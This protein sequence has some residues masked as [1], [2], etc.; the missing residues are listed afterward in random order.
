MRALFKTDA[1]VS[2]GFP[3]FA[4][5]YRVA[6]GIGE[7]PYHRSVRVCIRNKVGRNERR[8]LPMLQ[9]VVDEMGW[10]PGKR[11]R[12]PVGWKTKRPEFVKWIGGDSRRE[13]AMIFRT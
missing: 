6:S 13:V 2:D 4:F 12:C 8:R 7:D 5:V 3:R 10:Y 9:A 11:V 1:L